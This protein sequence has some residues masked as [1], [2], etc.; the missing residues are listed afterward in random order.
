MLAGAISAVTIGDWVSVV[1]LII[2]IWQIWRTGKI[3]KATQQAVVDATRRVGI[4]NVL[5]MVPELSRLERE[6]ED[7][8]RGNEEVALRR[9]LKEWRE[10][11]AELRGI[12]SNEKVGTPE[13]DQ[14]IKKSVAL[15]MVAKQAVMGGAETDLLQA[16]KKVRVA[17]E[18]VCVE[19]KM[20]AARI[21][22]M[23]TPL[24]ILEPASNEPQYNHQ[25][26]MRQQEEAVR[27]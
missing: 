17:I 10:L 14:T 16:T 25:Q 15:A 7:A 3:A 23:A 4:Y 18:D 27:G 1:G 12:L 20:L 22:T 24:G 9:L 5:L 11:G 26:D 19:T 8:A 21:R 13:L 6:I 2:V